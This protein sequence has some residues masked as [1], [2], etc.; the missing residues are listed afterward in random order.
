MDVKKRR[1]VSLFVSTNWDK[2][3]FK[4]KRHFIEVLKTKKTDKAVAQGYA[5]GAFVSILPTPGFGA[6]IAIAMVVIFKR[7]NKVS[8]FIAMAIWNVWTILPFY[9]LSIVIG[10]A[11]FDEKSLFCLKLIR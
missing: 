6:L 1:S 11:I 4:L 8:V 2:F 7:V 9:W 10:D 5:L 3:R